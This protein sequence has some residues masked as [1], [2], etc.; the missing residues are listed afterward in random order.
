MSRPLP[1]LEQL[2]HD[3]G[4]LG[5]DRLARAGLRRDPGLYNLLVHIVPPEV[6][7]DHAAGDLVADR[8]AQPP[9]P[10]CLYVHIAPCTGRCTFCHYAIEVNPSQDQ[11]ERY[12]RALEKEITARWSSLDD[13]SPVRSLMIG[14]G[15]PTYL[16]AA[17]LDKLF[18]HIHATVRLDHGIELTIEGSP[19]T[20]TRDKLQVLKDHGVNRL[21]LGIQSFDDAMLRL[22]GRRH[23]RRS[24]M[25]SLELARE[26]GFDHLNLDLIYALPGQTVEGWLADVAHAADFGIDS[27]TTYHL[28][29]RPDTVISRHASP[30]E[31][32][33]LLMHI[34]ALRVLEERG[35][36]QSL[37]DYFCRA[38]LE[39][40]QVQA[41]DKWRD[42][43]PVDG[44]GPEACS[45]RR[46]V[47]AFDHAEFSTWIEAVERADGPRGWPLAHGRML[48]IEEQ[49]A[50]RAMFGLKVLDPGGGLD[51]AAF[52]SDFGKTVDEVFGSV[53]K[54][55]VEAG[56]IVDTG[57][58]L[59]FTPGGTLLGDEVCQRFYTEELR[60]KMVSRVR[61]RA[62]G[63]TVAVPRGSEKQAIDS[64]E[65]L[66]IGAGVA[67]LHV[68]A[69]LAAD[70]GAG[71]LLVEA[72]DEIA[73]GATA[74]ALG[75]FRTQFADPL[76]AE[77]TVRSLLAYQKLAQGPEG[78]RLGLQ[79]DGYVFLVANAADRALCDQQAAIAQQHGQTMK[80]LDPKQLTDLIP[81]IAVGDLLGAWY[82]PEDGRLDPHGV[83]W[84]ARRAILDRGGRLLLDTPVKKLR[85][86]KGSVVG[87]DTERGWI[88]ARQVVLC[89]GAATPQLLKS[90]GVDLPLA[91]D[92]RRILMAQGI[93]LPKYP[94]PLVLG[95]T[96]PL[97]FRPESNG[98]LV[99]ARE[100]SND[101]DLPWDAVVRE[102]AIERLP[103]LKNARW[104]P[105]WSGQQTHS[106]DGR[107]LVG[108]CPGLEGVILCTALGGAGIMHAPAVAALA[109]GWV[110]GTADGAVAEELDPRR[111]GLGQIDP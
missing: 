44:V 33:N 65:V 93:D 27:L 10:L 41:R 30:A 71:V 47:I 45:R 104:I 42:M 58:H 96:P 97:Y 25:Q 54:E 105:G 92:K 109:A 110:L 85:L 80:W 98:L 39:T 32:S 64:A 103:A 34:G 84:L 5:L 60:R 88:A 83:A 106:R 2:R 63:S 91:I 82:G 21:S 67:G 1:T 61:V 7:R 102:R 36:R 68:A 14:G 50:Q 3:L 70:L 75:G 26:V 73:R 56:A 66:V 49:M 62:E 99:S 90:A 74:A 31:D 16:T 111:A 24:A 57:T 101:D 11:T 37:V 48:S 89:T 81:G 87:V 52:A 19:E 6:A 40:A 4:A 18:K 8:L 28:R 69:A 53:P 9:G 100:L 46:D 72:E 79:R 12:L 77:L 23:D 86:H 76:L 51:K 15:T 35:Y 107:P 13:R 78:H 59:Q 95:Q 55:L 22:L 94:G 38:E 43:Q 17:Q 20:I 108:P 29:K